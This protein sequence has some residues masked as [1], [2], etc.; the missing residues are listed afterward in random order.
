MNLTEP[1]T[2][3][4]VAPTPSAASDPLAPVPARPPAGRP[5]ELCGGP[6]A[7]VVGGRCLCP[8]CYHL[9][10]ACCPEF[11]AW[12]AWAEAEPLPPPTDPSAPTDTGPPAVGPAAGPSLSQVKV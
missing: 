11:G 7:L 10:G 9:S 8:D 3:P 1:V 6:A 12:D 4:D 2:P 5:C